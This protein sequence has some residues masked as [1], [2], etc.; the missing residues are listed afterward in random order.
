M[1]SVNKVS[2]E[3]STFNIIKETD[4]NPDLSQAQWEHQQ[5]VVNS[6]DLSGLTAAE[7]EKVRTMLREEYN[8]FAA[9][10]YDIENVDTIKIKINLKDDIPCQATYNSIPQLLHQERK[11]YI[12]DLLN[13]R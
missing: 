5:R 9:D 13:R 6:I 10:D 12:G 3:Q 7:R 1:P 11:H 4:I 8:V 2:S